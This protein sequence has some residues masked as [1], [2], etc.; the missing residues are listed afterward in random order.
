MLKPLSFVKRPAVSSINSCLHMHC[1]WNR[2]CSYW[3][4]LCITNGY[5][6]L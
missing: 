5:W 4:A 1:H 3:C 2:H 6:R